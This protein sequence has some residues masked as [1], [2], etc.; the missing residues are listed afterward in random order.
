MH[1]FVNSCLDLEEELK[2]KIIYSNNNEDGMPCMRFV[3]QVRYPAGA[4]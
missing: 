2:K 4:G 3:L 1:I